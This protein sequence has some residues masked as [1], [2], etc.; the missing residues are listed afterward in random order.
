MS[1]FGPDMSFKK[2]NQ[3]ERCKSIQPAWQ[4]ICQECGSTRMT[5]IVARAKYIINEGVFSNSYT[6]A[7]YEVAHD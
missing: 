1:R 3:C 5:S 4:D 6:L 7:G 2:K